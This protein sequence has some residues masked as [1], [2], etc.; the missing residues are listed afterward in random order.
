VLN[1]LVDTCLIDIEL[2]ADRGDKGGD[3]LL[4]KRGN[5]STSIVVRTRPWT[6]LAT[7]PPM[8]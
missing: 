8:T 5:R 7:E 1:R 3:V 4:F 2:V 6:V